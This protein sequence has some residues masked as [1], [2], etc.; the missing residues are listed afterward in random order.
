MKIENNIYTY[1]LL[2]AL[3]FL[4]AGA[5]LGFWS[6]RELR[7]MVSHQFNEEQ[8]VI[9]QNIAHQIERELDVLKRELSLLKKGEFSFYSPDDAQKEI[10]KHTFGRVFE[11]GVREIEII[12]LKNKKVTTFRPYR[13]WSIRDLPEIIGDSLPPLEFFDNNPVWVSLSVIR[14]SEIVLKLGMALEGGIPG[15]IIFNV[16]A[17]WF[18]SLLMKDV[19]SGKTGYAWLIDGGGHFLYHP[20]SEFIGRNAFSAREEAY[21]DIQ[22]EKINFIQT[23][24]MLK[25][26]QGVGWYYSGWHRGITGQIKKLIAYSPVHISDSPHQGWSVAVVSPISEIEGMVQKSYMRQILMQGFILVIVLSGA[27]GILFYE[28]RLSRSLEDEVNQRTEELKRSEEKYRSLVESAEDF[29]F[30][31]DEGG[32]FLSMNS[33]TANFFGCRPDDL[34]GNPLSALFEKSIADRQIQIIQQVFQKGKSLRH[35]FDLKIDDSE[36]WI[37]TSFMPLKDEGGDV[38]AV[39]CIARDITESKRLERQLIN[40]EKL[41]SLGTLAAG[42]AH[43]INN[44]LS[45][46]L[47]FCDLLI[48]NTDENSQTYDD[49]K[50]I[51]RQGNDCKEV[52][53]NLLSFARLDQGSSEYAD[54]NNCLED[55]IRVVQHTLEIN[56]IEL[57]LRLSD[58]LPT[59]KGDDRQLQQVFLN[60]INNALAAMPDGGRLS[61]LTH[62][63][64]DRTKVVAIF[65]DDGTGIKERNM[66]HIFEPFFTTKP[67]GEGTGLGLFVSY[68]IIAKYGGSLD[69][70][71]H[72]SDS[73]GKPRGTTFTVKLWGV[74]G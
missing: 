67:P 3:V 27:S 58:D 46:I 73:P 7:Q 71:S 40:A 9:A 4:G 19:K 52:V 23:E 32:S 61:I 70:V 38:G 68:G 21:P 45:I 66:D 62:L 44:P 72:V 63:D 34:L 29:I 17:R 55:I 65:Q 26:S 47:G 60:I 74:R 12:D 69:C 48:R 8:L 13:D 54:V 57:I 36:T 35:D 56:N 51:E 30:T 49:L 31:V 53:E 6:S 24:E 43:E 14:A 10:A 59:V 20:K 37:N 11:Q 15:V 39:L 25:G 5:A 50:T 41:A 28:K 42:V 22:F 1:V 64:R 33:F 16:D 18:L 2:S